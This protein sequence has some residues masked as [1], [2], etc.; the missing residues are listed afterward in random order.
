M[1][2]VVSGSGNSANVADKSR[3]LSQ[4]LTR[5]FEGVGCLTTNVH[6]DADLHHDLDPGMSHRIITI[7]GY[8]ANFKIFAF[9]YVSIDCNIWGI[10]C[11]VEV[12]AHKMLI[13][14]FLSFTHT[15]TILM[16]IFP[17]EHG[18]AG[19]PLNSPSPFHL[20]FKF[21][22]SFNFKDL[23]KKFSAAY[24]QCLNQIRISS[25]FT[26]S[27]LSNGIFTNSAVTCENA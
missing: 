24:V 23:K 9:N 14:H 11:I 13:F 22:F 8:W 20:F 15:R 18:L 1:A 21:Q 26:V 12:C 10:C 25:Q 7:T 17:G 27:S 19:C 4:I 6:F 5:F 16:A 3:I 2:F